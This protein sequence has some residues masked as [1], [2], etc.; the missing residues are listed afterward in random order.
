M[1]FLYWLSA[2]GLYLSN[3]PCAGL[4]V[5]SFDGPALSSE[6]L[7][8]LGVP[9]GPRL[10]SHGRICLF[11]PDS[12]LDWGPTCFHYFVP[13]CSHA[14]VAAA[15]E[16]VLASRISPFPLGVHD[17]SVHALRRSRPPVSK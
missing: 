13:P 12:A 5:S 1:P 8:T 2:H 14:L 7:T 17:L 15:C 6:D 11:P 4:C 16:C 9:F 10:V 3:L